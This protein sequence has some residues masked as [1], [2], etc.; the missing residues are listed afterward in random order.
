MLYVSSPMHPPHLEVR[1]TYLLKFKP[2]LCYCR[3]SQGFSQSLLVGR[4]GLRVEFLFQPYLLP[5][6]LSTRMMLLLY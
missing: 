4:E 6:N 2:F 1:E 5:Q 3:R